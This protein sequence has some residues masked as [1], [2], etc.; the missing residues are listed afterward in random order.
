MKDDQP[1]TRRPWGGYTVLART[2]DVW[3]KKL[4]LQAGHRISL[5][6]HRL[7]RELWILLWGRVE[8]QVGSR[9]WCCLPGATVQVPRTWCHRLTA[10]SSACVL[11]V[12]SGRVLEHDIERLADD[13]GRI[14]LG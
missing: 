9:R 5:Q 1:V 10:V 7:R 3:V 11:E 6:R 13:Y 8:V 2:H 12:A 4:Y 14:A